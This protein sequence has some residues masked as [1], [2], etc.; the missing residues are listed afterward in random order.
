VQVIE[1][2]AGPDFDPVLAG[3][4][5]AVRF[6]QSW[7]RDVGG[8]V[9]VRPG[10]RHA[11]F[12][13][14]VP[15]GLTVSGLLGVRVLTPGRVRVKVLALEGEQPLVQAMSPAEIVVPSDRIY[16]SPRKELQARYR[17]GERWTFIPVGKRPIAAQGAA[18]ALDGNYGVVYD[19][20]LSLENPTN[21]ERRVEIALSPDAGDARGVFWIEGQFVEAPALSPPGDAVLASFRLG[22]G[23]SRQ[24]PIRTL[25]VAGSA[26]PARIVVRAPNPYPKTPARP[27]GATALQ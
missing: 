27:Q 12:G 17:V 13:Q 16:P 15:R 25:P 26:Y 23:E 18:R 2:A 4:K 8:I 21:E 6:C 20:G 1:G 11:I 9:V 19:I 3:H 24:I 10:T 22:P 5:A 14:R 7:S